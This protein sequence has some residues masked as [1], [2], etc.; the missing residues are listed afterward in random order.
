MGLVSQ[1]GGAVE[2]VIGSTTVGPRGRDESPVADPLR[3]D[4]GVP[5]VVDALFAGLNTM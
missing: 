5:S 3:V 1:Q 4:C 2:V